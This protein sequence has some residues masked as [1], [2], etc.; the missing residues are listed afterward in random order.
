MKFDDVLKNIN[1]IPTTNI[2]GK[3]YVIIQ[4]EW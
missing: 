4:R 3:V 1:I 2:I